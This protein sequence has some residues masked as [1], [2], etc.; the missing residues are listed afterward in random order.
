M[1]EGW[2]IGRKSLDLVMY[3]NYFYNEN[4][5]FGILGK[6]LQYLLEPYHVIESNTVTLWDPRR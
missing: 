5:F 6:K 3:L 4:I 2:L 1:Y